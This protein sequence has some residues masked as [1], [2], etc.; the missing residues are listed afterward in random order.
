M[1]YIETIKQLKKRVLIL[2]LKGSL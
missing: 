1:L 2:G